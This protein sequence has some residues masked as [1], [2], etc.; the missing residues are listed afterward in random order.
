MFVLFL[1]SVKASTRGA[2]DAAVISFVALKTEITRRSESLVRC[3]ATLCATIDHL[4]LL[5]KQSPRSTSRGS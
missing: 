3:L 1:K 4:T 5:E 2:F